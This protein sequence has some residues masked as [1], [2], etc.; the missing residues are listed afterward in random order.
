LETRSLENPIHILIVDDS[1]SD[2]LLLVREL[3]RGGYTVAHQ[4]VD[5]FAEMASALEN[6]FW[7]MILCDYSMPGLSPY[8]GL[9]LLRT[10]QLNIPFIVISGVVGE[11]SAVDVMKAGARD[12][13]LKDNLKRLI[14]AIQR[15]VQDAKERKQ[16]TENEE[17]LRESE[18]QFRQLAD[19]TPVMIW[20]AGL[21]RQYEYFNKGWLDF[22]GRTMQQESGTGW[23]HSIHPD[24]YEQCLRTYTTAFDAR[25]SF[26]MEFRMRRY[27]GV[28]R[29]VFDSGVPRTTETG[30]FLGFVGSCID[31]TEL[32]GA[33]SRLETHNRALTSLQAG[34]LEIGAELN[35]PMLLRRIIKRATDLLNVQRGGGIYLYDA[36]A[37][38]LRLEA[39]SGIIDERI[40]STLELDEDVAGRVFQTRRSLIVNDYT[41]WQGQATMLVSEPASALLGVPLVTQGRTEGVL[42]I[43]AN[44]HKRSFDQNDMQ[45]AELFAAQAATALHNAQLYS[46]AQREIFERKEAEIALRERTNQQAVVARL[47]LLALQG[48]ELQELMDAVVI[49]VANGLSAEY[50]KIL[51][52]L[53]DGE[54][55]LLKAGVGWRDGLVG[56]ALVGAQMDSQAGY[57]LFSDAPVIVRDLRTETR[58]DGP[59]LLRDHKVVSGISTIIISGSKPYGVLGVHTAQL[60]EFGEDDIRF[61]QSVANLLGAAIQ[62]SRDEA[63]IAQTDQEY[64]QLFE[65]SHEGIFITSQDGQII[66]VNPALADMLGQSREDILRATALDFYD[67]PQERA[68]FR[69]QIEQDGYVTDYP[70]TLRLKDGTLKHILVNAIL[71]QSDD[72]TILGYFGMIRDVT[73]KG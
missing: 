71:R 66:S 56:H 33:T 2:A 23:T 15:E 55:L 44:A 35:V 26:T 20:R 43:V 63:V 18:R 68:A 17:A 48:M 70:L 53:P 40:G 54:A 57:T 60:H 8:D 12:F 69:E 51:E 62:H 49:A 22:T 31:I 4:H 5:N 58:F 1:E 10:K 21:D 9:K 38:V 3:R 28:Y 27:D 45:L 42:L 59:A 34:A 73:E 61:V 64:R 65:A 25:E 24:D 29:W 13:V 67:D 7:D 36:E 16:R 19:A 14:P 50:C 11:E 32:K 46:A 47:G 6:E 41:S 39:T 37:H 72:G 30:E 52:L